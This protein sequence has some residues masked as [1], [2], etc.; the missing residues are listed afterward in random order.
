MKRELRGKFTET[1]I[2]TKL[3]RSHTS[4]LKAHLN[5][6]EQKEANTTKIAGN[7]QT[8]D[9]KLIKQ[10]QR[11]QFTEINNWSFEKINKVDKPLAKRLRDNQITKMRKY[12]GDIRADTEEMQGTIRSYFKSLYSTKLEEIP[13]TK[14]KSI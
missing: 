13:H 9:L 12:K 5:A 11:E 6:L 1:S 3:T 10:K 7:N 4:N 2:T 14:V 8:Q